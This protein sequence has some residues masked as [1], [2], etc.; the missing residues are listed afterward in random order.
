MKELGASNNR[1][2][3]N[4][5]RN[6][7]RRANNHLNRAV[8]VGNIPYNYSN[9]LPNLMV[10][11]ISSL[12]TPEYG[13]SNFFQ[14]NTPIGGQLLNQS[15]QAYQH[16]FYPGGYNS[17]FPYNGHPQLPRGTFAGYPPLY[18]GG[19]SVPTPY[20][21]YPVFPHP[22]GFPANGTYG[23]Y[24]PP[25]PADYGSQISY[26][27]HFVPAQ[28]NQFHVGGLAGGYI[29][30][31]PQGVYS[32]NVQGGEYTIP[33]PV[34]DNSQNMQIPQFTQGGHQWDNAPQPNKHLQYLASNMDVRIFENPISKDGISEGA[35]EGNTTC[36]TPEREP[37]PMSTERESKDLSNSYTI[38]P[39]ATSNRESICIPNLDDSLAIELLSS[40]RRV[41]PHTPTQLEGQ[42]MHSTYMKND[43]ADPIVLSDEENDTSGSISPWS[44]ESCVKRAVRQILGLSKGPD[45]SLL[46]ST[47]IE[48]ALKGLSSPRNTW[49]MDSGV[50]T[51]IK[52]AS[53]YHGSLCSQLPARSKLDG[54]DVHIWPCCNNNHWFL[55]V[56]GRTTKTVHVFDSLW[57]YRVGTNEEEGLF[58]ALIRDNETV[59]G[60]GSLWTFS[61]ES[62]QL[63]TDGVS[64]GLFLLRNVEVAI[65]DLD[66]IPITR[67][68]LTPDYLRYRYA[69]I[70]ATTLEDT[71][72]KLSM[73]T[74]LRN[75]ERSNTDAINQGRDLAESLNIQ[76]IPN[77]DLNGKPVAEHGLPDAE[78]VRHS[79]ANPPRQRF[80]HTTRCQP[81]AHGS[82]D[83]VKDA[84]ISPMNSPSSS[85][86]RHDSIVHAKKSSNAPLMSSPSYGTAHTHIPGP[87]H[88]TLSEEERTTRYLPIDDRI[89]KLKDAR[90]FIVVFRRSPAAAASKSSHHYESRAKDFVRDFTQNVFDCKYEEQVMLFFSGFSAHRPI[91]SVGNIGLTRKG[92][93]RNTP[94]VDFV[95]YTVLE[96]R[97]TTIYIGIR[98][99]EGLGV[100]P[101]AWS[102]WHYSIRHLNTVI[103]VDESKTRDTDRSLWH[104]AETSQYLV[105][106]LADLA[107][108]LNGEESTPEAL[109]FLIQLDRSHEARVTFPKGVPRGRNAD[110]FADMARQLQGTM[111]CPHCNAFLTIGNDNCRRKYMNHIQRCHPLLAPNPNQL[112]CPV[113][114]CISRDLSIKYI[115]QHI[116]YHMK[117]IGI[118]G[119]MIE[120]TYI[121]RGGRQ[122]ARRRAPTIDDTKYRFKCQAVDCL[123]ISGQYHDSQRSLDLHHQFYHP[124]EWDDILKKESTLQPVSLGILDPHTSSTSK[125]IDN[126]YIRSEDQE[127]ITSFVN[128]DTRVT[129]DSD[130]EGFKNK[131][132]HGRNTVVYNADDT[133]DG[134]DQLVTLPAKR[135]RKV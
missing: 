118:E 31:T 32:G 24:I 26:N 1:R 89:K 82:I 28:P 107:K 129:N 45:A 92:L 62:C 30:S 50:Y 120:H 108:L 44:H 134:T 46:N 23:G 83:T 114:G 79:T 49:I 12:S 115:P 56:M 17:N 123:Y 27:G 7:A 57:A 74:L 81:L 110:R 125:D 2:G 39:L 112:C 99:I 122:A 52:D 61:I 3:K 130:D 64:C 6:Q 38:D 75:F 54:I 100:K 124:C 135:R 19:Y 51:N 41:T 25:Y 66:N 4:Y 103:V 132:R 22:G 21:E 34:Y 70:V 65:A 67:H 84:E 76:A 97:F 77:I 78:V 35:G 90:R 131:H 101:A 37:A 40:P 14:Q 113:P 106:I 105:F 94:E 133:Y 13:Y 72:T 87:I 91:A 10:S 80:Q 47:S 88:I 111:R 11:L 73:F 96:P 63:Q 102:N 53:M 59:Y 98:G 20:H 33:I 16:G 109:E 8:D 5:W 93:P 126:D 55:V 127:F 85:T 43:H 116:K 117:S 68:G 69:H 119:Y 15:F 18:T 36:H 95:R 86:A 71:P 48:M 128:N 29:P 9:E 104:Q 58:R 42:G 60:N 121:N